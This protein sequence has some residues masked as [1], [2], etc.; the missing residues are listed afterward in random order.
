MKRSRGKKFHK[1]GPEPKKLPRVHIH[2]KPYIGSK[3]ITGIANNLSVYGSVDDEVEEF[4]KEVY[5]V[6]EEALAKKYNKSQRQ[7]E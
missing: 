2:I 6:I 7:K 3:Y 4:A 5:D 1:Q